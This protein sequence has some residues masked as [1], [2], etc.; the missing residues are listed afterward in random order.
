MPKTVLV[1]T[2]DVPLVDGGHRVIARELVRALVACGHRAEVVTTP[3]NRFGR[4][5]EGYLATWLTDVGVTG[6]GD[7]V[8]QVI[9]LRYPAWAVRHPRHVPW[10]VHPMREYYDLWEPFAATLSRRG[11]I[12]EEVRRRLV[13]AL[14]RHLLGSERT[15]AVFAI[16]AAVA[17][18]L[19]RFLGIAARPLHPPAPER[20]Y[21]TDGYERF[22]LGVSRLHRWKRLDLLVDAAGLD[23]SLSVVIAGDGP[24]REALIARA[25][26]CGAGDRIRFAGAVSD[27]EL[28]DLYARARAVFFGPY[29]EDYGFVTAEAFR[30][31]KPVVTCTDSGGA[32]E[33]VEDGVNGAIVPPEAPAVAAA[34]ARLAG[35]ES[36]AEKLGEAGFARAARLSWP[37]TVRT[38][39]GDDA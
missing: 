30:S 35:D 29:N 18:R 5:L 26:A 10:V 32:L 14:D 38:L 12:K 22:I 39:L 23:R 33:L 6:Y 16:S 20:P 15:A 21:R 19:D 34:L 17:D 7:P 3:S 31:R 27:A 36:L 28:I 2:S 8:D 1:V 4:T 9:S 25:A 37:E 24:E 11:R 13:H